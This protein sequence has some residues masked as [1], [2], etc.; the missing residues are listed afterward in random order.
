M[1]KEKIMAYPTKD[2]KPQNKGKAFAPCPACKNAMA[3][4]KMGACIKGMK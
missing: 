4:R 3:C 2:K 1:V